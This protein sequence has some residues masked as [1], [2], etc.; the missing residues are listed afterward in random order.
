[1]TCVTAHSRPRSSTPA[2]SPAESGLGLYPQASGTTTAEWSGHCGWDQ[3]AAS[4]LLHLLSECVLNGRR[5]P[6]EWPLLAGIHPRVAAQ[7]SDDLLRYF[8][9]G[10]FWDLLSSV[11]SQGVGGKF[12]ANRPA[13]VWAHVDGALDSPR[14]RNR[15]K[16]VSCPG[17]AG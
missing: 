2:V 17:T 10:V 12:K 14:V 7:G 9:A 6:P 15:L 3:L 13:W 5:C 11:S 8:P 4:G 16:S 1:M